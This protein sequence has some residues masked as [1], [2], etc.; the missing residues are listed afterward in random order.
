M[1][2]MK[3][4]ELASRM[5]KMAVV[6]KTMTGIMNNAAWA[7]AL[8]AHDQVKKHRNYR[9]GV[10]RAFVDCFD[11]L[12]DY[13]R[14]LIYPK[15]SRLFCLDDMPADVRKALGDI[16]ER[17]YYDFWASLGQLAYQMKHEW[18][19]M[20][21]NKY[22]IA[23]DGHGIK[24]PDLVAW[25]YTA[26]AMFKMAIDTYDDLILVGTNQY[27]LSPTTQ[28]NAFR[29]MRLTA[30]LASWTRGLIMMD[31]AA[32]EM[33]L[34]PFETDNIKL[35]TEQVLAQFEDPD[36]IYSSLIQ[37]IDDYGTD[38]FKTPGYVDMAKRYFRAMA[39]ETEV[40]S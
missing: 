16:T 9:Q 20:L 11:R 6:H 3:Y 13:E 12:R 18:V 35:A 28:E 31:R 22:R 5:G 24:Q 26:E 1:K 32:Y 38:V 15:G 34:T 8:E 25:G 2:K 7:C 30:P 40:E 27:H 39:R 14:A 4:E 37:N 19:T 17:E 10:R 23:L 29:Q 36:T 33:T 21:W